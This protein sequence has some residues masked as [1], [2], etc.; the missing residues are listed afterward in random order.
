MKHILLIIYNWIDNNV[1]H[2]NKAQRQNISDLDAKQ[3]ANILL[4]IK[5]A[6]FM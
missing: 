1:E 4:K 6:V 2:L 3:L 5:A